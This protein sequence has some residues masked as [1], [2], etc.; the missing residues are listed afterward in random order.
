MLVVGLLVIIEVFDVD[1]KLEYNR[2]NPFSVSIAVQVQRHSNAK[3][4]YV[5]FSL[6]TSFLSLSATKW[7][8]A[9]SKYP[10][11]VKRV[12]GTCPTVFRN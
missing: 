4:Y 1:I 5:L 12:I 11:L 7:D 8:F 2:I 3:L 6:V 9:E 10:V